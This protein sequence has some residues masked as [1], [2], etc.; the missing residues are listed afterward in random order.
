MTTEQAEQMLADPQTQQMMRMMN[1]DPKT[2]ASDPASG[3]GYEY[4]AQNPQAMQMLRQQNP[5]AM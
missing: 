4:L 1:V 3:G 2:L 5:Q